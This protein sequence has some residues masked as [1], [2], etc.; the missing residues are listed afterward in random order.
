MRPFLPA[1]LGVAALFLALAS[2][3]G[4]PAGMLPD[5]QAAEAGATAAVTVNPEL[6]PEPGPKTAAASGGPRAN[7]HPRYGAEI[8][9]HFVI[10]GLDKYGPGLGAG[11]SVTIPIWQNTPFKGFDDDI[12]FGI[13]LDW[14]RYAGYKPL[15]PRGST[16][17]T[18]AFYVPVYVQWNVWL[19]SRASLF[20]EPTLMFRFA[21]Y[22]DT[23]P[24]DNCQDKVRVLPTGSIGLRFRIV[25][26]VAA[27]IRVGWPLVT[28]G[29]SWL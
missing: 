11:L 6:P 20:V 8:E 28:I 1:N 14:V 18:Q 24:L 7:W 5:A 22:P 27:T 25:N 21:S 4:A 13:G 26:H 15:E 3:A 12:S 2:F 23:C 9:P 19:G 17:L 29:A 16:V 10:A